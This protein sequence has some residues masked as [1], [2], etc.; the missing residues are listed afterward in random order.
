MI[1]L[2]TPLVWIVFP[3]L[4]AAVLL[5]IQRRERLVT[6]LATILTAG[7]AFLAWLLPVKELFF[8]SRWTI[9]LSDNWSVLGR[10]FILGAAERP[11]LIV[12]YLTAAFWFGASYVARPGRGFVPLGLGIVVVLTAAIA[13]EPFLYA[14]LL[15]ELAVLLSIPLLIPAPGAFQR[16]ILRYLTYQTLGMPFILFAGWMLTGIETAPAEPAL[17]LRLSLLI[18][19]GFAFLV[20]VFPFHSW[21]PMLMEEAHPY[22]VAFIFLLMPGAITFFGIYFL[23]RYVWLR[24]SEGLCVVLRSTGVL[25]VAFAGL[26]AAFQRHLGRMLGYAVILEIG[27]SLIAICLKEHSLGFGQEN[28][29]GVGTNSAIFFVSLLPRSISL[30]VWALAL[31]FIQRQTPTL[32]FFDVQGI[33][34]RLPVAG[35]ALI[36]AHFSLV[37]LPLLAGYPVRIALLNS[38]AQTSFYTSLGVL[39]G[40]VGLMTGS[41]RTL[42]VLVMGVESDWHS[43]ETWGQRFYLILGMIALI[44]VGLFPQWFLPFV[45]DLAQVFP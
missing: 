4:L 38:L 37:G 36:F 32:R 24:D 45:A 44:V 39:L 12:L 14:A 18:G 3:A 22:A 5:L 10:Q 42:A 15:I 11:A 25:M 7:L 2:S 6:G 30:G 41:L 16:G 34:R 23:D 17:V 31:T 35:S 33:A 43:V 13:V 9:S 8:I 20:G 26:W 21:I 27:M 28:G 1:S 40:M 29:V 19:L